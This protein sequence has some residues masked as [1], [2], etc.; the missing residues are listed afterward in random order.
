[1]ET[2][3]SQID[4]RLFSLAANTPHEN[5]RNPYKSTHKKKKTPKLFLPYPEPF[6]KGSILA[7]Q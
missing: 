3:D 5:N 6:P 7:G 4:P 1:M 2:P